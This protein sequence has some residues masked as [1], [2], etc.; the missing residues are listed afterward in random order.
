MSIA[1]IV[2][3]LEESELGR[4]KGCLGVQ[5]SASILNSDMSVANDV[6]L[7]VE[8]LGRRIVRRCSIGEG[9]GGEVDHLDLNLEVLVGSDVISILRVHED[10]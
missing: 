3:A 10:A 5:A 4:I 2:D 8:V 9:T 1:S 6:A 7:T